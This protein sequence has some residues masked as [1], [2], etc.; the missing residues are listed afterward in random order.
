MFDK[1]FVD[2]QSNDKV[3]LIGWRSQADFQQA[4]GALSTRPEMQAFF[5][6]LDV[7]AYQALTLSSND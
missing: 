3:V 1:E 7:K 6:I 5:G 4:L 2:L